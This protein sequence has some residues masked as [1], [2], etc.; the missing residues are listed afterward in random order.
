MNKLGYNGIS[1]LG[2][3]LGITELRF[4]VNRDRGDVLRMLNDGM[5][6]L[7]E[8]GEYDRIYRKWFVRDLSADESLKIL[9]AAKEATLPAY[10]PYTRETRGAAVLTATG[11][12]YKGTSIENVSEYSTG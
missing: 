6:R 1:T 4:A 5:R 7:I 10:T 12:I 8:S 3:P 2:T 9:N 11:Q